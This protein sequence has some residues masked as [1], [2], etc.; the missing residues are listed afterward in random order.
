[1]LRNRKKAE[2]RNQI[3]EISYPSKMPEKNDSEP[4]ACRNEKSENVALT[5]ADGIQCTC[6]SRTTLCLLY[7]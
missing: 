4:S 6:E 1:M 2:G 3:S 7:L 5:R